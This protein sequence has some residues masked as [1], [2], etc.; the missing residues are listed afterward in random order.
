MIRDMEVDMVGLMVTCDLK[1]L[2]G[3]VCCMLIESTPARREHPAGPG[4]PPSSSKPN[5]FAQYSRVHS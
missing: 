4:R 1:Q 2:C 5:K 3:G